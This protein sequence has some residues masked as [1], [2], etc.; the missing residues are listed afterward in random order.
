MKAGEGYE[1]KSV[2]PSKTYDVGNTSDADDGNGAIE[3]E[4]ED[5]ERLALEK[6]GGEVRNPVDL[7]LPNKKE[8]DQ[9]WV[10]G[11]IPYRNW[12]EVC[13]RSTGRE[14]D[15]QKDKGKERK[16]LEY[17]SISVFLGMSLASNG[18]S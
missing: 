1:E 13:V 5:A 18:R 14:M 2:S 16:I 15:H 17:F 9:H 10:R 12:C 11:H 6:D 4:G 7:L 3:F 8:V